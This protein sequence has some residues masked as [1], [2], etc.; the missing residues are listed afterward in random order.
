M[1]P[2]STPEE[3]NTAA[4]YTATVTGGSFSNQTIVH[5]ARARVSKSHHRGERAWAIAVLIVAGLVDVALA[6]NAFDSALRLP[7]I[8]SWFVAVGVSMLAVAGAFASGVMLKN[9]AWWAALGAL[10]VPAGVAVALFILRLHAN[11]GGVGVSFESDAGSLTGSV[12]E[13]ILAPVMLIVM[14]ATTILAVID[15][16]RLADP[17]RT[18]FLGV[19]DAFDAAATALANKTGRVARLRDELIIQRSVLGRINYDKDVALK[20]LEA[21]ADELNEWARVEA[22]R[23]QGNP[24]ATTGIREPAPRVE[25][26]KIPGM[27]NKTEPAAGNAD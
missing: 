5:G 21:V 27:A 17:E 7:E 10:A 2:L 12:D 18:R 14:A 15:G 9:K 11:H 1:I 4:T 8:V 20:A 19:S 16:W 22:V 23:A 13:T 6:K 25:T 3:P 26:N 24:R